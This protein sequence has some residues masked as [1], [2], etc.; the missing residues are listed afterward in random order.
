MAVRPVTLEPVK[1]SPEVGL[2]AAP[3]GAVAGAVG[4]LTLVPSTVGDVVPIPV[5]A[6]PAAEGTVAGP[7]DD[8]V[9]AEEVDAPGPEAELVAVVATFGHELPEEV[10]GPLDEL[11]MLPEEPPEA[12]QLVESVAT[13]VDVVHEVLSRPVPDEAPPEEVPPDDVIPDE[14]ELEAESDGLQFDEV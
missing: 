4:A 9:P 12:G 14:T 11:D 2:V 13:V 7:P 10:D 8:E 5:P 6:T 1:A 3:A